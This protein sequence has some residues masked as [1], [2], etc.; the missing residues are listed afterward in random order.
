MSREIDIKIYYNLEICNHI[1]SISD[2]LL[3]SLGVHRSNLNFAIP[4]WDK[5]ELDSFAVLPSRT[6]TR[7]SWSSGTTYRAFYFFN[8]FLNPQHCFLDI[9]AVVTYNNITNAYR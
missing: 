4:F 2:W 8:F 6:P 9:F 5:R 3:L 1:A 7:W